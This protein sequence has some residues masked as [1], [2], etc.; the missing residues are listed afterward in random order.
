MS[1]RSLP[2]QSDRPMNEMCFSKVG[3]LAFI[4]MIIN[5]TAEMESKSQKIGVVVAAAEKYSGFTRFYCRR[6]TRCVE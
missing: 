2:E 6:V 5:C 4:P 3:F 1:S